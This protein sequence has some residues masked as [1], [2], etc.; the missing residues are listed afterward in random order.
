MELIG[1][2]WTWLFEFNFSI[3]YVKFEMLINVYIFASLMMINII[4]YMFN[5][6][7]SCNSSRCASAANV[8]CRDV[9]VFGAKNILHNR[10]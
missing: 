8:V 4:V 1:L 5:V 10:I 6:W 3:R 2:L 9:N 7:S